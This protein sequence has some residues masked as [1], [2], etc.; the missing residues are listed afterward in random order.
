MNLYEQTRLTLDDLVNVKDFNYKEN[1]DYVLKKI[2]NEFIPGSAASTPATNGGIIN[3]GQ[4][5][6]IHTGDSTE[7]IADRL[8]VRH[9]A[10]LF[11]AGGG[12]GLSLE[13]NMEFVGN[14]FGVKGLT[15]KNNSIYLTETAVSNNGTENTSVGVG[16]GAVS[17]T[18]NSVNI[19]NGTGSV[20][21]GDNC[22]NVG[23]SA[24]GGLQGDNSCSFGY[25]SGNTSQGQGSCSFGN[26]AGQINQGDY[27]FAGGNLAGQNN[28]P[29][30]SII[31]NANDTAAVP[32][33]T[34]AIRFVA[35]STDVEFLGNK[36]IMNGNDM[37]NYQHAEVLYFIAG[38]VTKIN[39]PEKILETVR[40]EGVSIS[41]TVFF[42]VKKTG[43][44]SVRY[45]NDNDVFKYDAGTP[46]SISVVLR[47]HHNGFCMC[48][49]FFGS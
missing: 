36:L 11:V 27:S 16:A 18:N 3:N 38:K 34:N 35:G 14:K 17:T 29:E 23:H 2:G 49:T 41:F 15:L 33:A 1:G 12:L 45:N 6:E 26:L 25:Q 24:G 32:T 30:R 20:T 13:D 47:D 5:L 7:I 37:F 8:E 9:Q 10:G 40:V 28:Q 44:Y 42:S 21:G 46:Q 48:F 22:T 43:Y 31:I 4:G 39:D 19:G